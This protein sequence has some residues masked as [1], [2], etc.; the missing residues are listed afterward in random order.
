MEEIDQKIKEYSTF[1]EN[2]L[3][4][5]YDAAETARKESAKTVS[6]Y[7]ELLEKLEI[8]M[9]S[10]QESDKGQTAVVEQQ[11]DLG[12]RTI[13]C[14][15][16]ATDPSTVCV[17][18]GMGFHV[19]LRIAEALAFVKKRILFLEKNHVARKERKANEIREHLRSSQMILD[20]LQQERLNMG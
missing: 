10:Q 18:V 15:A 20:Q 2:I 1:V 3:G 5:Q 4:P 19:E 6:E 12:Y 7:K 14:N 16:V 8:M 11:V 17:H 13:Y 9:R